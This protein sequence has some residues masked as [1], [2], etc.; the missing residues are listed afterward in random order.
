MNIGMQDV[1]NLAWK[2]ALVQGGK[3]A[4][5]L[6]DSYSSERSAIGDQVLSSTGRMTRVALLHN[7]LLR[8]L[9]DLA[10]GT[11]TR[12]PAIQKRLVD[13]LTE[14]D[15]HYAH[16]PLSATPHGAA[17]QPAAGARTPD[18]V[19]GATRLHGLLGGGRFVLLSVGVAS[20]AVPPELQGLVAA[21]A[22]TAAQG[23]DDGHHYLVRPDGYLALSTRGDDAAAIFGWLRRFDVSAS[24]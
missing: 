2:L 3:V 15:L 14:L 7:P 8:E 21:A 4:P 17:S 5:V 1:F 11:L 20:P 19:L 6:L 22:T 9:R 12:L 23:Y 10:V 24:N 16:S 18:A 13:Q